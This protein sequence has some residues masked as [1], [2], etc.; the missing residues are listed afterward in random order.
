[1]FLIILD[2]EARKLYEDI[3]PFE[4]VL[5]A[6]ATYRATRL[7][8]NDAV[9]AWI[10]EQLYDI[11]KTGRSLSLI[12]PETGPRR[13]LV[14]LFS[15]PWCMSLSMAAGI[16]FF[17]LLFEWFFFVV[18]LLALSAAAAATQALVKRAVS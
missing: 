8:M 4:F 2:T 17:F 5:L 9:T 13:V 6:L 16:A 12:Q 7:F 11:K 15:C 18:L 10:R 1:M 3:T 14:D